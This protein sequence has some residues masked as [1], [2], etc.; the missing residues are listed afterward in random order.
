MD[1]D[2]ARSGLSERNVE[3]LT[4]KYKN[5]KLLHR[6]TVPISP[7]ELHKKIALHAFGENYKNCVF[8]YDSARDFVDGDMYNDT[9]V[10]ALME[11]F[12]NIREAGGTVCINHHATKNGKNIDGS[13]EFV[14]SLDA[15]YRMYQNS[16]TPGLL[17]LDMINEKPRL[18]EGDFGFTI[19][20]E[21]LELRSMDERIARINADD[22]IFVNQVKEM[23]TGAHN[24]LGQSELL[25]KMGLKKSDRSARARL[26]AFAGTFW[27]VTPGAR[28]AKIY[29]L[30]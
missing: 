17:H 19:V 8:I 25:T 22:K 16:R 27:N 7:Q 11:S 3:M 14:K 13:G 29:N 26:E 23:L 12:K 1:F 28:N 20:T 6:S 10:R 9:K 30:I 5:F 2:N 15:L 18:T 24:G 21:S 4:S